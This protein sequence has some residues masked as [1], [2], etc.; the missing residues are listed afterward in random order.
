MRTTSATIEMSGAL[1][2]NQSGETFWA[3][4]GSFGCGFVP[5]PVLWADSSIKLAAERDRLTLSKR[6]V[7]LESLFQRGSSAPG[8]PSRELTQCRTP[9]PSI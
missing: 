5:L 8:L 6:I 4:S 1:W 3:V 7:T 9:S 2:L